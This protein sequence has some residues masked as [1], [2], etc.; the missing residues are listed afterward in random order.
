LVGAALLGSS[1]QVYQG[2]NIENQTLNLGLCAERVALIAALAA[3]EREFKAIAIAARGAEPVTPCGAC[4]QMLWEFAGDIPVICKSVDGE[5]EVFSLAELLPKPFK[6][7][8]QPGGGRG[9]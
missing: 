5:E 1:G 7:S 8:P 9:R 4:R 6:G 2:C 3:G